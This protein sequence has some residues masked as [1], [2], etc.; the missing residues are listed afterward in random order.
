MRDESLFCIINIMP[1]MLSIELNLLENSFNSHI[2]ML[3]LFIYF[4]YYNINLIWRYILLLFPRHLNTKRRSLWSTPKASVIRWKHTSKMESKQADSDGCFFKVQCSCFKQTSVLQIFY[5][6]AFLN[7]KWWANWYPE[8]WRF[9]F[10]S[11]GQ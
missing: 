3:F 9:S 10:L 2:N 1:Q 5:E 6:S 7:E 11:A 8:H 4:S